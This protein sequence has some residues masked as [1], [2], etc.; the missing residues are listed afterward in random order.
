MDCNINNIKNFI[1][2]SIIS[3]DDYNKLPK[4][5]EDALIQQQFYFYKKDNGTIINIQFITVALLFVIFDLEILFL[6]P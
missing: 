6:L 3:I 4:I 2:D 5:E 1:G